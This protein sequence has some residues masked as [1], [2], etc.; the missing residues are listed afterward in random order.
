VALKVMLVDESPIY[1]YG[2]AVTVSVT[3]TVFSATPESAE[4]TV[5]VAL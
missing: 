4:R 2:A 3:L 5:S 1:G